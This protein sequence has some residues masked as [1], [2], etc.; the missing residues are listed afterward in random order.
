VAGVE[1]I[2]IDRRR[3]V[4]H[5]GVVLAS[6]DLARTAHVGGQLIHLV[7]T[8]VDDPVARALIPQVANNE[9]VGFGL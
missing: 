2:Q 4:H 8:A 5:I 6:K 3:I 7:K 9:I 1:H